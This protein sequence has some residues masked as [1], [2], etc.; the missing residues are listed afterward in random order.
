MWRSLSF[1][2]NPTRR[3]KLVG[4]KDDPIMGSILMDAIAK[5]ASKHIRRDYY[6]TREAFSGKAMTKF[7][8]RIS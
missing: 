1:I 8:G 5:H 3:Q 7:D 4:I 6:M 2:Q